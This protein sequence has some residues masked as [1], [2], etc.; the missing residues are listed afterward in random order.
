MFSNIQ[1]SCKE[2][3]RS[4]LLGIL[5]EHVKGNLVQFGR[6]LWLQSVGIS[7]GSILSP[8]LCSFYYAHLEKSVI[9][10]LLEETKESFPLRAHCAFHDQYV[11]SSPEYLMLRLIDDI[12]FISTSKMQ[13]VSLCCRLKR[14][15]SDY[16]CHMNRKK[17]YMN[18]DI[19]E[20]FNGL[21][22]KRVYIGDDGMPF[23]PWSGLLINCQTLEI[24]ADYARFI[25]LQSLIA[26]MFC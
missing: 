23:I 19:Y 14:G 12:L 16:N 25:S 8:L 15:I 22:G 5:H 6:H 21:K 1:F 24:Q 3:E 13:A 18:F 9:F 10:P 11:T 26:C 4:A 2:M 20:P 7:Q 17:F